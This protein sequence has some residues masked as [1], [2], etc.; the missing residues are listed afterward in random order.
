MTKN[1]HLVLGYQ[2]KL[3]KVV[4]TRQGGSHL[5]RGKVDA[6]TPAVHPV[7]PRVQIDRSSLGFETSLRQVSGLPRLRDFPL[8]RFKPGYVC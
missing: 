4:L 2:L 7:V 8:Q 6:H 5:V 1:V 3:S